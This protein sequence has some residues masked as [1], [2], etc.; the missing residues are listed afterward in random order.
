MDKFPVRSDPSLNCTSV[1]KHLTESLNIV[2]I[3]RLHHPVD[4]E[5]S[6]FSHVHESYSRIDYFFIDSKLLPNVFASKYHNILISDHSA[7]TLSFDFGWAKPSYIWRFNTYLL[8]D[9]KFCQHISDSLTEFFEINDKGDVSDSVLWETFKVVMRGHIISYEST[10][11]KLRQ[12]RLV[13]LDACLPQ[14][15]K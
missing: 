8:S 5:Y 3:W 1:I 9:V 4:K 6:F 10:A 11:K 15:G 12:K 14:L 13:E 2:D 7:V